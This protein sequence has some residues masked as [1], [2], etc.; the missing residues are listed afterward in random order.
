M[1]EEH[2]LYAPTVSHTEKVFE[3]RVYERMK[4]LFDVTENGTNE[5]W[6]AEQL[7]EKVLGMEALV[8]G[9]GTPKITKEVMANAGELKIIAHSAGSVRGMLADVFH[10]YIVPRQIV[11][12]SA[13]GAIAY[14]VAESTIGLMLMLTHRWMDQALAIRSKGVWRDP[15]ITSNAQF[16]S[17]ATVG[18]VS[19]SKI[20]REVMRLLAP[21]D[22]RL[23][24]YDPF[25]T[26]WEAGR[27]G[28]ERAD[29]D[30]LFE[31]A[32]IVTLHA[33][34]IPE[35]D[36][37]IT[38]AH[39]A[40]LRDGAALINTSRGSVIDHD[41]LLEEC[42]SGRILAA[43]DVTDPEPLSPDSEFRKLE[44]VIITPH[45][46]GS[47]FYGYHKIGGQTLAALEDFF[48]KRPVE[49]AI[50]YDHWPRLA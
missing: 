25:L 18:I 24:I 21:W 2:V 9:W 40:K 19:A 28:V 6:T 4:D 43:L 1:C 30:T 36:R 50:A 13:N 38:A 26:E 33:P 42:K 5:N 29:L 3:P 48:G 14:N 37:M 47:G 17:G 11:V 46:S 7:A 41:A 49:G 16:L 35:T 15:S 31:Q 39:L 10:E 44:N 23:L 12:F 27:M 45:A 22:V 32:D 8:T 20:G 34:K